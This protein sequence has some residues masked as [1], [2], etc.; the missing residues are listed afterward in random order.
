[1]TPSP[2]TIHLDVLLNGLVDIFV[3]LTRGRRFTNAE[4]DN[5]RTHL[6]P[7]TNK[8]GE[9]TFSDFAT[10]R[11][12]FNKIRIK[13]QFRKIWC[14]AR[15]TISS[16]SGNG[17]LVYQN[18]SHR[19]I[20]SF[21]GRRVKYLKVFVTFYKLK[22]GYS[23]A[24]RPALCKRLHL[25]IQRRSFCGFRTPNAAFILCIKLQVNNVYSLLAK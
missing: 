5:L 4:L 8:D 20:S 17:F 3:Y 19:R 7:I 6:L 14:N 22:V 23:L 15:R 24:K 21:I 11:N 1:M 18:W 10:V 12:K 2:T 13:N 9:V 25:V 16:L